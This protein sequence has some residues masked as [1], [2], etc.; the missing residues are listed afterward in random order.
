MVMTDEEQKALAWAI[1]MI[2]PR[3]D[4]HNESISAKMADIL[5]GILDKSKQGEKK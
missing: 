5:Q 1:A 2:R 4:K 3:D